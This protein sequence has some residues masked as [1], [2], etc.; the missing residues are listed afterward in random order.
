MDIYNWNNVTTGMLVI[1][2][3]IGV[4]MNHIIFEEL[5]NNS[6][7]IQKYIDKIQSYCFINCD[8]CSDITNLRDENYYTLG[9]ADAKKCLMTAWEI[10]HMIFH[11]FIGYFYNIYIS[12]SISVGYELYEHYFKSCGSFLDL[13]YNMTGF[14]I[15]NHLKFH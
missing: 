6:E 1:L 9:N 15:G 2:V 10:S 4:I 12:V 8:N 7:D 3:I 11:I 5:D 14:L 13:G